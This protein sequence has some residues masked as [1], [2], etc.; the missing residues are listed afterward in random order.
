MHTLLNWILWLGEAP[1]TRFRYA[2]L[3]HAFEDWKYFSVFAYSAKDADDI[4]RRKFYELIEREAE[5]S[6]ELYA[7]DHEPVCL[8]KGQRNNPSHMCGGLFIY[9]LRLVLRSRCRSARACAISAAGVV[10]SGSARDGHIDAGI[11]GSLLLRCCRGRA[12]VA[13]PQEGAKRHD[14]QQHDN[15]HR[16]A[17]IVFA[18]DDALCSLCRIIYNSCHKK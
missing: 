7:I 12:I 5:F 1:K 15:R 14:R 13:H 3:E 17:A 10:A 4:A 2:Y 16:P 9:L 8:V 18:F 11:S 6:F